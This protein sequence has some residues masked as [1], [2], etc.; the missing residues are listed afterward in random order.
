MNR[1][2]IAELIRALRA[3]T[4]ANGCTEGEAASAAEKVAKLLEQH[5]M[6]LDETEMRDS[7]FTHERHDQDDLVGRCIYR[8]AAAIAYM[9]DIRYW[10][11]KAGEKPAITFFGFSHE[12][13][14]ASY[15]LDICRNAMTT[16]S[17]KIAHECRL[18]RVNVRRRRVVSFLDGMADRLAQRIRGLKPKAPTGKGLV[19]LRNQLIDDELE[20]QGYAL[21]KKRGR[22]SFDNYDE[23]HKG[24]EAGERVALNP[25][26]ARQKEGGRI[27]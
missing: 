10:A 21:E 4:T 19:I 5:N 12:V 6:T 8:V 22:L 17:D 23:Y 16:Q 24:Q 25:A 15:L 9:I 1:K 18:L 2:K 7:H 3:K 13:E 26:V 27:T 20:S 11:S 14:I